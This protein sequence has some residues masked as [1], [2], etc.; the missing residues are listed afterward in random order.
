[1]AQPTLSGLTLNA[2][3]G[4]D[5]LLGDVVDSK[6]AQAILVG[7]S[8]GDGAANVVMAD[9]GLPIVAQSGATF[10][11]TQS[12]TWNVTNAGTFA[13]QVDG[14]ALT[15]L[16]LIDDAVAAD[17]AAYGKGVLVQGDDGTDRR[18]VLVDEQ[19]HVQVDVIAS[20]L[21]SGAA[22]EAKQD[23][24]IGHVD[25]LESSVADAVTALQVMD[26]WDETNRC[27]VNLVVGQAG[28]AAGAGAVGANTPRMTLASD[29]PAVAHLANVVTSLGV[30]DDW[31]DGADRCRVAGAAAEDAAA[32]GNPLLAGGR[33]DA[34]ER[35]LDAGDAGALALSAQG[36]AM[37]AAQSSY[38]FDG[39]TRCEVKR[40]SGVASSSGDNAL[41][42]AVAGKK[43]RILAIALLA[44]SATATSAYLHTSSDADVL[45]ESGNP[46]PVAMDADGDN[47]GGFVLGWNPGGWT[48]TSTANEALNLNLSGAVAVIYLLAYIEVD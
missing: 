2:G 45:G 15:A 32:A 19:G 46:L 12:G 30:V 42:A 31:D 34:S 21:P 5:S 25:G 43:I 38:L 33:Y 17:G 18:A 39:A 14:D 41:V 1:M 7:Y 35:T 37:T 29:D 3:S 9:T 44:T 22:T 27:K 36:W 13:V 4:G 11:C 28:I 48:Q 16:Q 47:T 20:A 8:T 6:F 24:L 23:T 10:A 40:K 26:D